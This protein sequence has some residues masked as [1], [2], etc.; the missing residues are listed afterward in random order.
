[1]FRLMVTWDMVQCITFEMPVVENNGFGFGMVFLSNVQ[2][3]IN[4]F[5]VWA[6][7]ILC[8]DLR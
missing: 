7:A 5:P 3:E 8:S 2:A 6:A 4:V 1:V